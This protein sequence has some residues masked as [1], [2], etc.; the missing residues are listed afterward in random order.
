MDSA[1]F[2]FPEGV[3]THIRVPLRITMRQIISPFSLKSSRFGA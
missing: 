2:Y 3:T 1:G